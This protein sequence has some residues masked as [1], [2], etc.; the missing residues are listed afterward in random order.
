MLKGKLINLRLVEEGDLDE[1]YR[2]NSDISQRGEYWHYSL[3]TRGSLKKRYADTG[4][5]NNDYGTMLITDKDDRIVGDITYF[6]GLWYMPGYE[7]GYQIFRKEDRG[8]GYV[9]E[10]LK[11]FT[12]YLFASK[13]INR[14]EIELAQGNIGSRRVAEKCGF[15][16]EGLKRGA[17]Y[18]NGKYENCELLGLLREECPSLEEVI[19]R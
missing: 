6:K 15:K 4:L 17:N 9:S 2:L 19:E 14:L 3:Q 11:I 10:A 5:W 16:Y 1:I 7:V 12:A 18:K 8:K 13:D